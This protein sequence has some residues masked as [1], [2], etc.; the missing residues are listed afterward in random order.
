MSD[1]SE[2]LATAASK[3]DEMDLNGDGHVD[4]DELVA[5]A[6]TLGGEASEEDQTAFFAT[7]DANADGKVSKAEFIAFFE[8]MYDTVIAPVVAQE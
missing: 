4:R 6:R 2:V 7:F 8:T 3:Y 5:F 1:R